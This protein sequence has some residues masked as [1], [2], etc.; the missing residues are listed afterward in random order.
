[1]Q[2]WEE[3]QKNFDRREKKQHSRTMIEFCHVSIEIKNS[4]ILKDISFSVQKGESLVV[5]GPSGS[6]KSTLLNSLCGLY[7]LSEGEI[8]FQGE[9]LCEKNVSSL[10]QKIAYIGQ[11]PFLGADRVNEALLLPFRFKSHKN[12]HPNT[13][14]IERVLKRLR[15]PLSILEKESDKIS[16]GEKQRI[17]IARALLLKKECFILDEITSALDEESIVSVLDLF[18]HPDYTL[19]SVS[20]ESRW[21]NFCQRNL[22]LEAGELTGDSH[23]SH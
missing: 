6:G 2:K 8:R 17:A 22:R 5:T 7:E 11:E 10:R 14:E 20:H 21:I 4:S 12:N 18:N 16:G 19:L 23:G 1:M 15:L 3:F 13:L 9:R